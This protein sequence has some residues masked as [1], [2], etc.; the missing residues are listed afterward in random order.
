MAASSPPPA[1]GKGPGI[2]GTLDSVSHFLRSIVA[3]FV[4]AVVGAA[5][6]LGYNTYFENELSQKKIEE[7]SQE[8]ETS[9]RD[10]EI[11]QREVERLNTAMRL[12][13]V[14]HRLAQ[15]RFVKQERT[16]PGDD[17]T[18]MTTLEFV[19]VD[20]EGRELEKPRRFTI[21]GDEVWVEAWVI[22]FQDEYV[23][24]GDL[25]RGTSICL[26]KSL[27]TKSMRERDDFPLE[28]VGSRPAAYSRGSEMSDLE[29]ELW[30]HFWDYAM[31][32]DKAE[33]KGVRV[34]NPQAVAARL[35]DGLRYTIELRASGGLSVKPEIVPTEAGPVVN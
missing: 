19:E 20:D 9:K 11:S 14:D 2:V 10:L 12:L 33:A 18:L 30:G 22:S 27:F 15:L 24:Q 1:P 35:R 28:A 17:S 5:G 26:F 23:E 6:Y 31:D 4:A 8:L 13:K 25:L 7:L 3:M 16:V 21:H 32:P 29:R 34:A